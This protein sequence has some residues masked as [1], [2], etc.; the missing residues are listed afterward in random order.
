[1]K[2]YFNV[3]IG[4]I[5]ILT[6]TFSFAVYVT[7]AGKT[8]TANLAPTSSFTFS[9][10]A[11]MPGD[12]IT[13]D[14]SASH[15]SDG[16]IIGYRWDFGDGNVITTVNPTATHSYPVDGAY[17]V[18]LTVTDDSLL[19]GSSSAIVQVNC[20]VFFRAVFM[21]TLIPIANVEVTAYRYN[22]TAWAAAPV[23]SNDLEIKYD[24]MTQ[25]NLASTSQQK[26]RNPGYTA[27]TLRENASN[28][29]FDIHQSNWDVYFK[30]QWGPYTAYW[31][32]ETTR[33]YSYNNG[34][35]ETHDYGTGHKA[36]WDATAGTYVIKTSHIQM[37]GV[38][39][40]ANHPIIVGILCPPTQQYYLT[41]RTD[42]LGITTIPGAGWYNKDTNATLTAPAQVAVSG[43][44]QYRFSYWD[45]DGTSRDAGVNPITVQMNVKDRKSVV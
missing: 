37:D 21:G 28:I 30:F 44:A 29:G 12:V 25:P 27:S 20:L 18:E 45:V 6:F 17:T 31:P 43:T 15:D 1:M 36:Y 33:V 9:P 22:G 26:Y 40:I 34:A 19:T 39:P 13:F 24:N 23:G 7:A 8:S 42:P 3:W 5:L 35:V 2:R 38:N 32:N 16:Y 4:I 14:A 11:P 10:L 41:T